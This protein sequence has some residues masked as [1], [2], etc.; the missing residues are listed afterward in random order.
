MSSCIEK[1]LSIGLESVMTDL[2]REEADASGLEA[3]ERIA[4]NFRRKGLAS[5]IMHAWKHC[6]S[7]KIHRSSEN[8]HIQQ[9]TQIQTMMQKR[10]KLL[11]DQISNE[12][13]Q[14]HTT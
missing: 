3:S 6:T 7:P 1:K 14:N 12:L 2:E 13:I 10:I 4:W 9:S 11:H 8:P 5:H